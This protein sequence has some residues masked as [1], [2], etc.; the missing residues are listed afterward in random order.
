MND[1]SNLPLASR[2]RLFGALAAWPA[3]CALS[4]AGALAP[5]NRA[6]AQ[7]AGAG[8]QADSRH[9]ATF[10]LSSAERAAQIR[11]RVPADLAAALRSKAQATLSRA[12]RPRA[13]VHTQG[14]LPHEQDHDASL[15]ARE[16]W[17]DTLLQALAFTVSADAGHTEVHADKAV[18]YLEAWLPIYASSSNPVDEAEL[19]DLL[20][21]FD[22]VQARLPAVTLGEARALG[23]RMAQGYLGERR[24]GDP[25][26]G[27]NNWQSHRVKLATAGAFLAGDAALIATAREVFFAHVIRNIDANGVTYDFGQ[28]DAMHYVVYDLQPLIVA[29][30]IA[31]AHG[32]DWYGA[33]Q[34]QGRLAAALHWLEPYAAGKLPHEEFVHSSVRFDARRAAAHVEGYAGPWRRGEAADLYWMAA[35][36]DARFAPLAAMLDPQLTTRALF[37]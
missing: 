3:F 19:V 35:R 36:L 8:S 20:F 34:A 7:S 26:T 24:V 22:L 18:A 29:A 12:P 10:V 33:P 30:S 25:S 27:L 9:S 1:A 14:L 15:L 32:E 4:A 16:D 11:E 31:A 21:G 5:L 37:A 17:H 23:R 6:Y 13:V 28:R 2:R